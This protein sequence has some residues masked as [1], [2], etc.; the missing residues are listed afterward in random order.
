[1]LDETY[2]NEDCCDAVE[3]DMLDCLYCFVAS[4]CLLST[5]ACTSP[6]CRKKHKAHDSSWPKE[7]TTWSTTH[8]AKVIIDPVATEPNFRTAS[9]EIPKNA[10]HVVIQPSSVQGAVLAAEAGE[11]D[12]A[13]SLEELADGRFYGA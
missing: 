3:Q 2:D 4:C 6:C 9:S 13:S 1:M 12:A 11:H 8:R 7:S 10:E 5:L